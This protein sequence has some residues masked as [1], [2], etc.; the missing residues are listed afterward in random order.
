MSSS[1]IF[2][3]VKEDLGSPLY[4]PLAVRLGPPD[5][6]EDQEAGCGEGEGLSHPLEVAPLHQYRN[7]FTAFLLHWDCR[8]DIIS[9]GGR[10]SEEGSVVLRPVFHEVEALGLVVVKSVSVAGEHVTAS[11]KHKRLRVLKDVCEPTD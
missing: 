1:G 8:G 6:I 4:L 5:D 10:G 11:F 9:G 2:L 3:Q 7:S